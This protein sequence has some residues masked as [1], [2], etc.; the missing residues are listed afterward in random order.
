VRKGLRE[1]I[2]RVQ[3]GLLMEGQLSQARDSTQEVKG[4]VEVG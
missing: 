2:E 3:L 1:I 4:G